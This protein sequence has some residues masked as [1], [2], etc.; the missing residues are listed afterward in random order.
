MSDL[1]ALAHRP[2]IGGNA[3][4]QVGVSDLLGVGP[5]AAARAG[6]FFFDS[7]LVVLPSAATELL[8]VSCLFTRFEPAQLFIGERCESG[9]IIVWMLASKS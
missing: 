1:A 4:A 7:Q 3:I 5:L 6:A 8:G 9:D 2:Q